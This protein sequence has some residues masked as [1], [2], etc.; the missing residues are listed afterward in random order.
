MVCLTYNL[1]RAIN[2]L[3][4]GGLKKLIKQQILLY[5]RSYKPFCATFLGSPGLLGRSAAF[6]RGAMAACGGKLRPENWGSG[7]FLTACVVFNPNNQTFTLNSGTYIIQASAPAYSVGTH[8][9]VLRNQQ[10]EKIVLFGTSE[11][12]AVVSPALLTGNQ[13]VSN[14]YGTL[15]VPSNMSQTFRLEHWVSTPNTNSKSLGVSLS[16]GSGAPNIY[17]RVIIEK[18]Q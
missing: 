18:I 6:G 3:G 5:L 9:I 14:L 12:S 11:F 15:T 17:A 10:D 8:R 1:C 4:A 16:S 2:I 7:G 13:S